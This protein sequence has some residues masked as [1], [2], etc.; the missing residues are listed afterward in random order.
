MPAKYSITNV[1]SPNSTFDSSIVNIYKCNCIDSGVKTK[2]NLSF[3][4][5]RKR[6]RSSRSR[7]PRRNRSREKSSSKSPRRRESSDKRR[8]SKK[9]S[10]K[11][12][13]KKASQSPRWVEVD[14]GDMGSPSRSKSK[15][16]GANA[17]RYDDDD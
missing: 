5:L 16:P 1:L 15:S 17:E 8:D 10:T 13:E 11:S 3:Y 7:S 2:C 9:S 12:P 4:P 6:S 14:N